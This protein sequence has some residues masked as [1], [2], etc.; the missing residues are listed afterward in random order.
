GVQTCALP[1]CPLPCRAVPGNRGP[2]LARPLAYADAA[3]VTRP[4]MR[5][6]LAF[7]SATIVDDP[8][9]EPPVLHRR[10]HRDLARLRML[11][12]VVHR[13]AHHQVQVMQRAA[14]SEST[15]LN[16]SHVK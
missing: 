6:S 2:D 9:H 16:S 7:E 3:K 13:F 1:I 11:E 10:G 12:R 15:R 5:Q 8:Q 14:R 4:A